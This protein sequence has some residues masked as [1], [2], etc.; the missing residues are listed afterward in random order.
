MSTLERD[1]IPH[2]SVS[3]Q[4]VAESLRHTLRPG[5]EVWAR[6][7]T[8]IW[9]AELLDHLA[10]SL[11]A[12][13]SVQLAEA[14]LPNV[15]AELAHPKSARG[16]AAVLFLHG[17]AFVAWGVAAYRP[18]VTRIAHAAKADVLSVDY[19]KA[20]ENPLTAA[21]SDGVDGYRWLLGK[22]FDPG[23]IAVVGDSAGGWLTFMVV[24]AIARAGLPRPE[25]IVA[26]SPLTDLDPAAKLSHPNA[27]TCAVFGPRALVAFTGVIDDANARGGAEIASPVD[28][29][30]RGMPRTLIQVGSEELVYPD[31]ETMAQRLSDADVPVRLQVWERQPHVF[32]L[33]APL[34]PESRRAIAE[35]GRFIQNA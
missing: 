3:S 32:Q 20:P 16:G 10:S 27:D 14:E 33:A 11:P 30:L 2:P 31:A 5:L 28:L 13:A 26:M 19:R 1:D 9:P 23:K 34:V 18:L 35:I 6:T 8:V 22:G 12:P 25:S 21:I 4:V 24:D 7:P 17:G 15:G 29:D